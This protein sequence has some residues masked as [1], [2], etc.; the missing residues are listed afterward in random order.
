MSSLAPVTA[1]KSCHLCQGLEVSPA[2]VALFIPGRSGLN[3]SWLHHSTQ[4]HILAFFWIYKIGAGVHLY[5]CVCV[6]Y[7][8]PP[9]SLNGTLAVNLPFKHSW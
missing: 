1:A 9:K 5:I 3:M 6:L 4:K 2:T 7:M 8:T